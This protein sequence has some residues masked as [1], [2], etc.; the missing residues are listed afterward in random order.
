MSKRSSYKRKAEKVSKIA[1]ERI[2]ILTELAVVALRSG[3]KDRAARY[4]DISLRIC[5]KTKVKMPKD[6]PFCKEC[7]MPLIPGYN[8]RV[9]VCREKVICTCDNCGNIKRIPYIRE[10]RT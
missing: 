7:L 4:V 10:K 2:G 8:E 5:R 9:R 6:F 3:K 1:E